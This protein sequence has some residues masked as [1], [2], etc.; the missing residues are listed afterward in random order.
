MQ[1][2]PDVKLRKTISTFYKI[3][4]KKW[5]YSFNYDIL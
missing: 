2:K 4:A 3:I 5:H 1:I